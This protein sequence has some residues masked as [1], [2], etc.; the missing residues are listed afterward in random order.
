ME[1][2]IIQVAYVIHYKRSGENSMFNL[3]KTVS[4]VRGGLLQ[5]EAT[6]Q[7]Y[8]D[9]QPS[10]QQ[11][12]F[13]LALPLILLNVIG[14]TVFSSILGGYS[15][16]YWGQSFIGAIFYGFVMSCF[17]IALSTAVF[18]ALAGAFGGKTHWQRGFAA[19]C[20]A[21]IPSII[22]SVVGSLIPFLGW[23][24]SIAG[25]IM[26][27]VF[28]YRILPLA[29][30]IPD[31]KRPFHFVI[32]L[33]ILIVING[34]VTMMMGFNMAARYAAE[35]EDG[36]EGFF[37]SSSSSFMSHLERQGE[38]MEEASKDRY[39]APADGK[40]STA[41][42]KQLV[43]TMEKVQQRFEREEQ[44]FEKLAQEMEDKEEA[45]LSDIG[46]VFSGVGNVVSIANSEME[47][48]KTAGGNWAEHEWVKEQLR[49][50]LLQQDGS[51]AIEHN[52]A[53]YQEYEEQLSDFF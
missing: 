43:R 39:E 28:T 49:V 36:D 26:S 11:T 23:L 30:D 41:Q 6:W 27:L 12:F 3:A 38:L 8:L 48:V 37:S 16:F 32:A 18:T 14:S 33:V 53:L 13:L 17:G 45:S 24:I 25:F 35:Y 44:R 20:L 7:D 10:F 47:L 21:M 19:I 46:K 15:G 34:M 52:Y 4:L 51:E 50:A 29:L 9:T 2:H 5:P 31:G 1:C 42:M 22:G 40:V